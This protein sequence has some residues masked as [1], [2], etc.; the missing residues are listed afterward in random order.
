MERDEIIE[1]LAILKLAYPA[2][3]AK[4]DGNQSESVIKLYE[5]MF[6]RDDTE[7]VMMAVK[8]CIETHTGYPPDVATIKKIMHSFLAV[9]NDEKT[10]QQLWAMYRKA[11]DD[12]FNREAP[13]FNALPSVL[14]EFAGSPGGMREHSLMDGDTFNSVVYSNFLKQVAIF[15]EREHYIA[16]LPESI[17]A[18]IAG[19]VEKIPPPRVVPPPTRPPATTELSYPFNQYKTIRFENDI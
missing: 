14:K 12:G 3:Y 17:R 7:I 1:M 19:R 13:A 18:I 4:I 10:P 2:Y 15:Q 6:A 9:I 11:L 5:K 8:E 16:V